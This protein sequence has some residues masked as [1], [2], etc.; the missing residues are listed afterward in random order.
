[1]AH[2]GKFYPVHFRRD[3][4]LNLR[5]FDAKYARAYN[6]IVLQAEGT[7]GIKLNGK[8]L[9]VHE[10][11][12][13]TF[14]M[15]KWE[16]EF[17]TVAGRSVAWL[18]VIAPGVGDPETGPEWQLIDSVLGSLAR[19]RPYLPPPISYVDLPA[20][21]VPGSITHPTVYRH[22]LSGEVRAGAML[23]KEYHNIFG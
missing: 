22:N 10:K 8:S 18:A 21:L 9:Y 13:P 6:T 3:L 12:G 11:D 17:T 20:R 7:L 4:S 2:V 1:M 14:E 5:Q 15:A 19:Y 23:W 16:S